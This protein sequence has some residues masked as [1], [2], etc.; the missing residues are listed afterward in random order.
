[1]NCPACNSSE[2]VFLGT[3]GAATWNRCRQCG[4]EYLVEPDARQTLRPVF[5]SVITSCGEAEDPIG[6][7]DRITTDGFNDDE[8]AI[9]C[10]RLQLSRDEIDWDTLQEMAM[11]EY[12]QSIGRC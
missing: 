12:L 10:E 7:L 3:L 5:D 6:E 1:M 4:W 11:D 8:V 9:F 2:G